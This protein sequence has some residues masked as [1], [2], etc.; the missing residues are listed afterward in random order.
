MARTVTPETWSMADVAPGDT[1]V[2]IYGTI[3]HRWWS[4][5][6]EVFSVTTYRGHDNVVFTDIRTGPNSGPLTYRADTPV[7]VYGPPK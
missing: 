5:H 4:E 7:K 6:L 1:I 2:A 3:A